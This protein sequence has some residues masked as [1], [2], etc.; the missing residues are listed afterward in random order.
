ML[1]LYG[2]VVAQCDNTGGKGYVMAL[3][4][5]TYKNGESWHYVTATQEWQRG[6]TV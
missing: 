5:S 2:N 3:G 6:G 4:D 1:A